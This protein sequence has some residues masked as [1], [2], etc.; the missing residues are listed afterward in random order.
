MEKKIE[1]W[2]KWLKHIRDDVEMLS[3]HQKIFS[4]IREI[5]SD[6]QYL[7]DQKENPFVRFLWNTYVGNTA[8]TL[9]RQIKRHQDNSLVQLLY[10]IRN[11]P[12]LLSRKHFV[13]LFSS[14]ERAVADTVFSQEFSG[15]DKDHINPEGVENDLYKIKTLGKKVEDV[16]DKRVDHYD[17]QPPKNEPNLR[18]VDECI[19]YLVELTRKYWFLFTGERLQ[20]DLLSLSDDW[21]EIF[22]E[23]WIPTDDMSSI[24]P[25]EWW[26]T[27]GDKEW[28]EWSP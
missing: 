13:A 14:T 26:N 2:K 9:R 1:K 21:Q 11:D 10:E 25:T 15:L 18:D 6:N 3:E 5:V 24:D 12:Q 7:K 28:D 20:S 17:V 22:R 27:E 23:P 19:G 16:A 4:D 8:I